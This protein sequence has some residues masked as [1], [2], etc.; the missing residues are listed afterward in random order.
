MPIAEGDMYDH[1]LFGNPVTPQA[2]CRVTV[3]GGTL[4]IS[5]PYNPQFVALVKSLPPDSRRFDADNKVWLVDAQYAQ[6]VRGWILSVYGEDI[7]DIAAST[8]QPQTET[9][10]LDVWYL[11]RTK[12]AGD[13][14]VANGMNAK[15]K[16]IFIFP[17][18]VLREWFEGL[19]VPSGAP[20]LY[21]VL[22]IG[23]GASADEIRSAY[24]RMARQW[25]PD[26]CREPGAHEMFIRIQE[27][28]EILNNPTTRA[29]YDAG[30]AL[31]ASLGKQADT[32]MGYGYRSPLRCGYVLAEGHERLGRFYV[33][34][35]LEWRDIETE[36]GT[37]TASWPAG[38]DKPVWNWV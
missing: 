7:G 16:W 33:T 1:D 14:Y 34:K 12:C 17:E 15:I 8:Q 24:R 26:I 29:K 2:R 10:I 19:S 4:R 21:G 11:G 35:I 22:G 38:A 32:E 20:T 27:A 18:H 30:L 23:R 36:H 25:H 6:S 9:R 31:E 37:L 13:E 3:Q 28:Y 5:T